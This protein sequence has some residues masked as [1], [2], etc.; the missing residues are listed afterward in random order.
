MEPS[1][2][3]EL[4]AIFV[5][6]KSDAE[7]KPGFGTNPDENST[8]QGTDC[9]ESVN[10]FNELGDREA[11]LNKFGVTEIPE[12]ETDF[13]AE[14][15]PLTKNVPEDV[16]VAANEEEVDQEG[17]GVADVTEPEVEAEHNVFDVAAKN[18]TRWCC[19][20]SSRTLSRPRLTSWWR[21]LTRGSCTP[22]LRLKT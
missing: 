6:I 17:F 1:G 3:H 10:K 5:K 9:S 7:L 12:S 21:S 14:E 22:S 13:Q 20:A 2:K 15:E 19:P 11:G 4:A 18:P 16:P 8:V